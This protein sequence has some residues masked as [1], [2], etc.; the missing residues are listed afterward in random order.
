VAEAGEGVEGSS[1]EDPELVEGPKL[2][3]TSAAKLPS[4]NNPQLSTPSNWV[5]LLP[6]DTTYQSRPSYIPG[7]LTPRQEAFAQFRFQGMPVMEAYHAAG[8]KGDTANL[9]SRLS[10]N[11]AVIARIAQ[12]NNGVE[13]ATGYQREHAIGD[14]IAIIQASPGQASEDHPYCETRVTSWGSYHRFPSKLGAIT[15]LARILGWHPPLGQCPTPPDP[16]AGFK[17][18]AA[19]LST[20]A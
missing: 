19:S 16:N 18:L 14:L 15:L 6:D 12:L 8:Y 13:S 7:E 1:L 4:T 10:S 9:A 3:S 20:R 11:P 5:R 17:S 2:P